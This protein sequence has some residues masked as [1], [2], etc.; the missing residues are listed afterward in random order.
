MSGVPFVA[1]TVHI[2]LQRIV[3]WRFRIY[4]RPSLMV[5]VTTEAIWT[6]SGTWLQHSQQL[7]IA[8]VS[9][10]EYLLAKS[11]VG[12]ALVQAFRE[13]AIAKAGR[14]LPGMTGIAIRIHSRTEGWLL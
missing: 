4:L 9:P 2:R 1:V 10:A 6:R 3:S 11:C 13:C 14:F 8:T 5:R 7:D 12:D